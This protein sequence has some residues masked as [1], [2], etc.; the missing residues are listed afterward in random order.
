MQRWFLATT[1]R[2]RRWRSSSRPRSSAR[3]PLHAVFFAP[4]EPARRRLLVGAARQ[5]IADATAFIL[6]IGEAGIGNWQVPEYDEALDKW[7][8]SDGHFRSLSCCCEGQTAPGLPFLRQ[9]HWIVTPSTRVRKR[10][11]AHVRCRVR[12]RHSPGELW[13]YT[14]PYRGLEAMEE[15]DSDYFFGRKRETVEVLSALAA[16]PDRLPMLIGNSGVGKSSLAQAGVLAALKRQAGRRRRRRRMRGRRPS[17][18]AANGAFSRSSPA[19]IRSSHW[20][21]RS[22]TP[23]NSRNRSGAGEASERLDRAVARRQGDVARSD[24]RDRAP[25]Q[26]ARSAQPAGLLSLRRSGRGALCARRGTPTPALLRTLVQA[27]ARPAPA[28]DD[29]HALR[30]PR[31]SAERR[32]AVQ[33]APADRRAAAARGRSCARSSAGR[34]NCSRPGSRATGLSTSSPGAPPRIRSRTSA[35]CRCCP[36]RSTTCGRR[37]CGRATARC[38]CRHKSFELGG[39]LVDRADKFLAAHP[40]AEDALRRVLTLRLAD[41]A[42]RRRA[43][44]APRRPRRIFPRGMAACLRACR[45]SQPPSCHRRP[46]RPARPMRRSRMRRSSG[47]GTSC[48]NGSPPSANS[49]LGEAG[50]KPRAAPGRRRRTHRN[51][52][53]CSWA[54]ALTQAQSWLAKRAEDFSATDRR[55]IAQ[56]TQRESKARGRARRAQALVY[57][58][59]V[60]MIAGSSAGSIRL[61]SRSNGAVLDVTA[62]HAGASSRP[63]S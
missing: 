56:S 5:E 4:D 40:G 41:R 61:S 26:G 6:L 25:P 16:T 9:L 60:G 48:A 22:S 20:S 27:L 43:D 62:V 15:K 21:I 51:T 17:R 37:W 13:R 32:A 11:R 14:S 12:R 2:I 1:R 46:P 24:R 42:R 54:L 44:A 31:P 53:R 58:L 10:R 57:V 59:L 8:K 33:G 23:G 3:I 50:S 35:R 34:R 49:W 55:F 28:R 52:T 30:L 45:L 39:V 63:M 18:T 47:A 38:V 19:P 29:E 36:T 7:V